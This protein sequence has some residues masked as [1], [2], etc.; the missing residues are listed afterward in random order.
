MQVLCD[1]QVL[2]PIYNCQTPEETYQEMLIEE[3]PKV[4]VKF[5]LYEELKELF[6]F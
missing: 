2:F 5:K 4:V 1:L 6:G 3:K